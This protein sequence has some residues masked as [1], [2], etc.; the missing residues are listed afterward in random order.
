M[1]SD[2]RTTSDSLKIVVL[3]ESRMTAG[4]GLHT[5]IGNNLNKSANVLEQ[6]YLYTI[7]SAVNIPQAKKGNESFMLSICSQALENLLKS[8]LHLYIY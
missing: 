6:P 4:D 5:K 2:R 3:S 7:S 1:S 8:I